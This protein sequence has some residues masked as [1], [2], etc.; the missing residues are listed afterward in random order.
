MSYES[1]VLGCF[2]PNAQLSLIFSDYLSVV[3]IP[4][5]DTAICNRSRRPQFLQIIR[6]ESCV[7][8]GNKERNF[9]CNAIIWLYNRSIKIRHLKCGGITNDTALMIGRFGGCVHWLLIYGSMINNIS[10]MKIIKGC[11]NL[12]SFNL[13]ECKE[14]TDLSIVALSEEC[15][16]KVS[17]TEE[18]E[19]VQ[20]PKID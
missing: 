17:H 2:V 13:S 5:F 11:P 18:V 20:A 6:S 15:R 12:R 7:W 14:I 8:L 16:V 9:N 3:D 4:R 1:D 10:M 19:F